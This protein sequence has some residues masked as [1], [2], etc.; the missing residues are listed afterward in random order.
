MRLNHITLVVADLERS[1]EF[2]RKL[3]LTQ[4]VDTPPRYARFRQR[5]GLQTA[6]VSVGPPAR[7]D[8]RAH[9]RDHLSRSRSRGPCIHVRLG[10]KGIPSMLDVR[11]VGTRRKEMKG[12]SFWVEHGARL[13]VGSLNPSEFSHLTEANSLAS[14]LLSNLLRVWCS[15]EGG[16]HATN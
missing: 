8:L 2:Y 5:I 10:Q 1:K 16:R 9:V 6:V 12:P 7:P 14:A 11:S 13:R 4:I 15:V 3:G